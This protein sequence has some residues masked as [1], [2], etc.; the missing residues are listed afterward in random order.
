MHRCI[1]GRY[2]DDYDRYHM[3]RG[4]GAS[5]LEALD[6]LIAQAPGWEKA[7]VLGSCM[8][9]GLGLASLRTL[10][11]RHEIH[12][13]S[14]AVDFQNR[15]RALPFL[16]RLGLEERYGN[17]IGPGGRF[18]LRDASIRSPPS[19]LVLRGWPLI[20]DCP[21]LVDLGASL[22]SLV[23]NLTIERCPKLRQLPDGLETIGMPGTETRP[24]GTEVRSNAFGDLRL[25]GCPNL[26]RFGSNTRIRGRIEVERCP[27]LEGIDLRRHQTDPFDLDS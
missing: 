22:A 16:R 8:P 13:L 14:V 7:A 26:V 10:L 19:G 4:S 11:G 6:A 2:S 27:G 5:A 23:G 24:D 20:T 18:L 25:A 21:E 15:R 9:R 12:P 17:W 1:L 3:L